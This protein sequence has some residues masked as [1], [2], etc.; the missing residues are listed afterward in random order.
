MLDHAQPAKLDF[1][2]GNLGTTGCPRATAQT[3]RF[4]RPLVGVAP[5]GWEER[6]RTRGGRVPQDRNESN[7]HVPTRQQPFLAE[8]TQG[9]AEEP[10]RAP[11][12]APTRAQPLRKRNLWLRPL[13]G[14][15][16]RLPA[17]GPRPFPCIVSYC[18]R[19]VRV[20]SAPAVV[21]PCPWYGLVMPRTGAIL[22]VGEGSRAAGGTLLT[23]C[24][25]CVVDG[26]P[27]PPGNFA[28][29]FTLGPHDGIQRN[30]R[31]PDAAV[32]VLADGVQGVW[33]TYLGQSCSKC[34]KMP[35]CFSK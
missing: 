35:N 8:D 29:H 10:V 6:L 34:P 3:L 27:S 16:P 33:D 11:T 28:Q 14:E 5:A 15:T 19:L 20:R 22:P 30:G 1:P 21:F 18:P 25:P 13:V 32:S 31:G 9:W 2:T 4:L 17:P 26:E 7:G 24:T 12:A 23:T